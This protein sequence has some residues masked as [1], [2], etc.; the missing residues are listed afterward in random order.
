MGHAGCQRHDQ[1][2]LRLGGCCRSEKWTR[3]RDIRETGGLAIEETRG[4]K[5]IIGE[6]HVSHKGTKEAKMPGSLVLLDDGRGM[7][8]LFVRG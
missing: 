3:D 7:S 8:L 6:K 2:S 5:T 4:K 1:I